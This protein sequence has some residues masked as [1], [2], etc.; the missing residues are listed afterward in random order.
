[1]RPKL[2][3]S[4]ELTHEMLGEPAGRLGIYFP[5]ISSIFPFYPT[6][7]TVPIPPFKLLVKNKNPG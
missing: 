2:D 4:Y 1:M 5:F 7:T 3:L 6:T